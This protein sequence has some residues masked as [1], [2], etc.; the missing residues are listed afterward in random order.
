MKK[1]IVLSIIDYKNKER[2]EIFTYDNKK[3]TLL[4]VEW[5]Y[6]GKPWEYIE[7][8]IADSNIEECINRLSEILRCNNVKYY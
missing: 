5:E 1:E 6:S 3:F 8:I 7:H 2:F 4:F